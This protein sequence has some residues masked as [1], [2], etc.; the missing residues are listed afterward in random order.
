MVVGI[1]PIALR[2]QTAETGQGSEGWSAIRTDRV[3]LRGK[4][5]SLS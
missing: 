5:P 4:S 2:Q 1:D 3:N